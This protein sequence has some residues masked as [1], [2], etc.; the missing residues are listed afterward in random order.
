MA[1]MEIKIHLNVVI[2][3]N[4]LP[5]VSLAALNVLFLMF[6]WSLDLRSILTLLFLWKY[7]R[8]QYFESSRVLRDR[9]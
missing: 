2:L 8:K 5:Y 9:S 7:A 6:L 4:R 1:I 3:D